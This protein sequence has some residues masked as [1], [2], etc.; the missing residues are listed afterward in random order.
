MARG[1]VLR[2]QLVPLLDEHLRP[3]H[4]RRAWDRYQ[5]MKATYRLGSPPMP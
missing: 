2:D 1:P 5:R 4:S 3:Q